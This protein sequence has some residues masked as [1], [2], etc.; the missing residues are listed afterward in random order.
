MAKISKIKLKNNQK[1]ANIGEKIAQLFL[2]KKKYSIR[3]TN[4]RYHCGEIDIVAKKGKTLIFIEVKTR[5]NW[6]FGYPEEAFTFQKQ[7]KL[8]EA[9][10]TYLFKNNIENSWQIDL[11]TIDLHGKRA[12]LRHYQAVSI[13]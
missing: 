11:I 1:T 6:Q 8:T 7:Q 4:V 12:S 5:T 3:Q 13:D 10:N 2:L 9:I